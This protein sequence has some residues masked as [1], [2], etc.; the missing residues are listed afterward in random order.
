[1]KDVITQIFK[2]LRLA[3]TRGAGKFPRPD[4]KCVLLL[5]LLNYVSHYE[6]RALFF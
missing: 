1:M 6:F 3:V 4:M 5:I 2:T